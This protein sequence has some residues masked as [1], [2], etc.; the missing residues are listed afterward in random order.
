[1]YIYFLCRTLKEI[2]A[3]DVG[4]NSTRRELAKRYS[5]PCKA[6][7]PIDRC[8][9]CQPLWAKNRRRLADCVLGFGRRATGGK[10]GRTYLVTDPSDDDVLNPRP[11]TL[12]HA[13]IQKR[14]LWIIFKRSMVIKL[15]QELIMQGDKTIDARGANVHIAYGAGITIQF[16]RNVIIHGLRIHDIV[17]KSGGMVRDSIDHFGL[18]TQSDADGISIFG[19][20]DIWIDHVSMTRCGDGLIDAIQG[21]TGITI[22][23]SHFTDHNKVKILYIVISA[24]I[25]K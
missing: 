19:S 3:T 11:G 7:N 25:F 5:G 22:S 18:R 4:W 15:S 21:S 17:S 16:V 10:A 20:Q 24:I 1:M 8:W 23:N 13:V 2:G 14:P 12:R 6:T 9:R